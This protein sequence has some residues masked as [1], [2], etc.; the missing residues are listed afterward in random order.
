MNEWMNSLAEGEWTNP[1]YALNPVLSHLLEPKRNWNLFLLLDENDYFAS[2]PLKLMALWRGPLAETALLSYHPL[3]RHANSTYCLC[4]G[5][6]RRGRGNSICN[7]LPPRLEHIRTRRWLKLQPWIAYSATCLRRAPCHC[8]TIPFSKQDLAFILSPF[9]AGLKIYRSW[10]LNGSS[11]IKSR[12]IRSLSITAF[13]SLW[14]A[15]IFHGRQRRE[16]TTATLD[17][18]DSPEWFS[19]MNCRKCCFHHPKL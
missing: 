4:A 2:S 3:A 13:L 16:Q 15:G 5:V 18:V 10:K 12:L 14:L 17:K 11:V 6:T 9:F 8:V 19:E 1:P 7:V